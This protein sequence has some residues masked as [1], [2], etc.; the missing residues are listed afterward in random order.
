MYIYIVTSGKYSEY[1]IDGVFTSRKRAEEYLQILQKRNEYGNYYIEAYEANGTKEISVD[2]FT[3]DGKVV[4][5]EVDG[6]FYKFYYSLDYELIDCLNIG[7][8]YPYAYANSQPTVERYNH[9]W[10]D[11]FTETFDKRL[12]FTVIAKDEETAKKIAQDIIAEY[13]YKKEIEEK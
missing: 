13:K 10:V 6:F 4:S 5:E 7:K 12:V 2:E 1:H 11:T 3:N 8:S 9:K